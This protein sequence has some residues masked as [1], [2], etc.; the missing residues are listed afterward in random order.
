[1][2]YFKSGTKAGVFKGVEEVGKIL[3]IAKGSITDCDIKADI[4]KL[5]NMAKIFSSP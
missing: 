5:E 3:M 2:N 1:M 4:S